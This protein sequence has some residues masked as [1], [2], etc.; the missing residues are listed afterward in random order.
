MAIAAEWEAERD[1]PFQRGTRTMRTYKLALS[2]AIILGAAAPGFAQQPR[3]AAPAAR[4][5]AVASM[6]CGDMS[7]MM[8]GMGDMGGMGAMNRMHRDSMRRGMGGMAGM[9]GMSGMMDSMGPPMPG[10][11]LMHKDQLKL[12][13]AQVSKLTTLQTQAENACAAH[14]KL[15]MTAHQSAAK[16]LDASAPDFDAFA[17]KL[18]EA[19]GHMIEGHVAMARAA[20][21]ARQEL[22]AEQ[23]QT[24]STLAKS[25]HRNP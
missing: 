15:A 20:V 21:A 18:R 2:T 17:A 25:M 9:T 14:M 24:L 7:G 3:P 4:G 8:P 16:M 13:T 11:L 22:T 5:P 10:M 23:R 6:H 19:A 1:I 12:T